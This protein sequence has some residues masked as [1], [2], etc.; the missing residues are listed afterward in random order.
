MSFDADFKVF[1]HNRCSPNTALS[2]F[3]SSPSPE[4]SAEASHSRY[5]TGGKNPSRTARQSVPACTRN[6]H[7]QMAPVSLNVELGGKTMERKQEKTQTDMEKHA[8]VNNNGGSNL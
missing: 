8:S 1:L 4:S 3:S 7:R 5:G 6:A 2:V